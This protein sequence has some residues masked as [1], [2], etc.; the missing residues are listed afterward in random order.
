ML[1]KIKV[2]VLP[3]DRMGVGHYRSIWPSVKIKEEYSNEIDLTISLSIDVNN[4]DYLKSFDIIHFHRS[5]GSDLDR[6]LELIKQ[7]NIDGVTTIMDIDDYWSPPSTHPMYEIIKKDNIDSK[8]EA[9]VKESKF[10]TTTTKIFADFIKDNFNKN[11]FVIPNAV[12]ETSKVWSLDSNENKPKD[13][14]QVS[15]I[16]GSSHLYD[17]ALLKDGFEKLSYDNSIK[18]KYQ[19]VLCGFDTRG[20]ITEIMPNN[21][22]ITRAI[23]PHETIW[24][25]FER[26]F[27]NN[28]K[29][30]ENNPDYVNWLNKI[31]KTGQENFLNE[32]YV[33]RWTLSLNEY[34]KHYDYA[35][36]CLAPLAKTCEEKSEKGTIT[37]KEHI[38]NKVKSELKI[39]EAGIK[40]KCLIAQDFGIYKDILEHGVTGF[41]VSDDK[42]DWD[43]YIKKLI[44]DKDLREKVS[45]NLHK[46]VLENYSM[47]KITK[48]RVQLYKDVKN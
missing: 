31:T 46:Y 27:T 9:I 3:S 36:I 22:K 42:K 15:W 19:I 14:V 16:G 4:Y 35:D 25:T 33:R 30:V 11:V 8:I 20:S 23:M 34:P 21:E 7:L 2:L 32:N 37:K 29:L 10:V 47:D 12:K 26:I 24:V 44:L 18:N 41:L 38:F 28:Y 5:I 39:I 17:L 48:S 43:K 40:K 6:S 1:K 45:E 13:K